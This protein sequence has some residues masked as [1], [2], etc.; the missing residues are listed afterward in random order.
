[1][2][3]YREGR[4]GKWSEGVSGALA[5]VEYHCCGVEGLAGWELDWE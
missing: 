1:M 5:W 4:K 2:R 3:L